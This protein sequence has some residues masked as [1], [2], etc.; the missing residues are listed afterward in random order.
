MASR[1][2]HLDA[3]EGHEVVYCHRCSH[4][5]YKDERP[6]SLTCPVCDGDITEIVSLDNDPRSMNDDPI[7]GFEHQQPN[8]RMRFPDSDSDPD[9]ADIEEHTHQGPGG[10]FGRRAVY[11]SPDGAGPGRRGRANPNNGEDIIRR[12]TEMLGGMGGPMMVGHSGPETLFTDGEGPHRVTYRRFTGGPGFTGGVGS[13]TITTGS[14][15]PPALGRARQAGGPGEMDPED[16]FQR[17]FADILG[18]VGPPPL[19]RDEPQPQSPNRGNGDNGGIGGGRPGDL[20][21]ALNQLFASLLTPGAIHGD[22]VYSQ[23][24]LDRIITNLMEAN[25]QS[26]APAPASEAAIATLPKK[27]LDEF[28]LGPELKGECTIC[29]DDM[30]VGDEVV[31]LPCKHWFHEECVVLWLK[32]HNSCPVCRAPIDG[33]AAGQSQPAADHDPSYLQHPQAESSAFSRPGASERRRSILRQRGE[34]RLDSIRD[35]ATPYERRQTPR[36]DSN[37]PPMHHASAQYSPRVR[38]PSPSSRRSSQS[39][40]ARDGRSSSNTGPLNWLRDQFTRDRRS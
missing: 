18:G 3:T 4:E 22:A 16:P 10:F 34:A 20:A 40:R 14:G 39:E 11:R 13:I 7:F 35:L 30:K 28:M 17:I 36:R 23:E 2:S 27:K 29:I 26:N 6:G 12:F 1:R 21:A 37:S 38:S 15:P 32:E 25:P 9:E 24:A 8:R 19:Q 31:V 5:W 33:N